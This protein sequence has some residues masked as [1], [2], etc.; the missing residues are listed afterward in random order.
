MQTAEEHVR[1]LAAGNNDLRLLVVSN[2]LPVTITKDASGAY[3]YKMS[4]GGL[5]SALSGLKR[6]MTF[7]WIGWP[8]IDIPLEERALVQK[9]LLEKHSCMPV[10]IDD[11][12][13]DMHYNGFSNRYGAMIPCVYII[14]PC[15]LFSWILWLDSLPDRDIHSECENALIVYGRC[16]VLIANANRFADF[17]TVLTLC[18]ASSGPCSITT[19][20][21]FHSMKTTGVRTSK[22]TASLPKPSLKLSR[23][24]IWSGF[25]TT[26]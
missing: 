18:V 6:M 5:V 2:R 17:A 20:A 1:E 15:P 14:C 19:Q 7:T 12:I 3:Q 13:A 21:R 23:R 26:I 8:G 11:E 10:F 4:S 16:Y 24:A 22:P 9:E 25:R